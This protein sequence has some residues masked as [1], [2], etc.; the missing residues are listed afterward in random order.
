M[1]SPDTD[2][3]LLLIHHYPQLP[4]SILF[5]TGRGENLRNIDIGRCYENIGQEHSD[6]LLGFHTLTGCDQAGRFNGK[7]KAFWWKHFLT[8][9]KYILDAISQLGKVLVALY[10]LR[11]STNF[12]QKLIKSLQILILF[13]VVYLNKCLRLVAYRTG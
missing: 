8:A 3:L 7:S 6:A 12:R 5:S 10:F 1:F 4:Q 9:D 2:V 13:L 11:R